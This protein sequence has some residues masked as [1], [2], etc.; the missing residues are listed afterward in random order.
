MTVCWSNAV[1]NELLLCESGTNYATD[2]FLL[3][4]WVCCWLELSV[5][6]ACLGSLGLVN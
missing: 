2:E 1:V 5:F 6:C 4:S 3:S